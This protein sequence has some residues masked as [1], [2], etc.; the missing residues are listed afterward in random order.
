MANT[1]PTNSIVPGME[2][3][4]RALRRFVYQHGAKVSSR[5]RKLAYREIEFREKLIAKAKKRGL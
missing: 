1:D 5:A 4:L 3:R 2:K